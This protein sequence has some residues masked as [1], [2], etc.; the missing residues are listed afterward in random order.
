MDKSNWKDFKNDHPPHKTDV[1][2]FYFDD[3]W[4]KEWK[5]GIGFIDNIW[6]IEGQEE[7]TQLDKVTHWM[8]LPDAPKGLID[9]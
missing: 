7:F 2:V 6:C 4:D 1:I 3:S 5:I 9:G 8:D